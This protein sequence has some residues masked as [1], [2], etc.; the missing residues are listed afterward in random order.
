MSRS[1]RPPRTRTRRRAGNSRDVPGRRVAQAR[2][3]VRRVRPP[4][5]RPHPR[6]RR[7]RLFCLCS[8]PAPEV[9][10]RFGAA[11][12]PS[13]PATVPSVPTVV[14]V[15]VFATAGLRWWLRWSLRRWRLRRLRRGAAEG[16]GRF[17]RR[18]HPR[19][20]P[21]L[22][23]SRRPLL[24]APSSCAFRRHFGFLL[25]RRCGILDDRGSRGRSG[26]ERA[27]DALQSRETSHARSSPARCFASASRAMI[28]PQP[29]HDTRPTPSVGA[30]PRRGRRRLVRRRG[31]CSVPPR[32]RRLRVRARASAEV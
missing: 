14:F 29:P 13:A 9:R 10:F 12:V 6:R 15:V 22:R 20:P 31:G 27:G 2:T 24:S 16:P 23:A 18:V 1:P 3:R 28:R 11:P 25:R 7:R 30:N 4:G 26:A 21:R 32:S 17:A 5:E 19:E 8:T